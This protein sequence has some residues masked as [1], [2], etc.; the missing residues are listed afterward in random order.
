MMPTFLREG[1]LPKNPVVA[2]DVRSKAEKLTL[3]D[4]ELLYWRPEREH[5]DSRSD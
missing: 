4:D 5:L 1:V 3:E 2:E